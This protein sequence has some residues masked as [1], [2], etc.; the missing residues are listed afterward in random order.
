MDFSVGMGG[1]GFNPTAMDAFST[2]LARMPGYLEEAQQRK[3][4]KSD[5][6]LQDALIE[7]KAKRLALREAR[8]AAG[9]QLGAREASR[10]GGGSE[11][12]TRRFHTN[13]M[14]LDLIQSRDPWAGR[15]YGQTVGQGYFNMPAA[16]ALTYGQ[17]VFPNG[18]DAYAALL[19][20]A[21]GVDPEAQAKLGE[22]RNPGMPG[23]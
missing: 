18:F 1:P 2:L 22:R 12:P 9:P 6:A 14:D 23:F 4:A 15:G 20:A 3:R 10:S 19:K 7:R 13:R 21:G 11:D 5:A 16:S 8:G 17:D